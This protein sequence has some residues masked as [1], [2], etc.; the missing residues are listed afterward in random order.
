VTPGLREQLDIPLRALLAFFA[1]V[2]LIFVL[3][4]LDDS[5]RGA[6]DLEKMGVR[7]M[8]EIPDRSR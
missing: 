3:D 8:G 2:A 7:V 1:G 5:V 6:G 4:Y